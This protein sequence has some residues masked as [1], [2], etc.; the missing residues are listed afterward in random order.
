MMTLKRLIQGNGAILANASY[1]LGTGIATSGLGF[2]Y[3]WLAARFYPQAAVGIASAVISAMMLIGTIAMMGLGTLLIGELP[4]HPGQELSLIATAGVISGAVSIL[5]SL[6]FAGILLLGSNDLQILVHDPGYFLVFVVGVIL[7]T[8]TMVIDQAFIGLLHS[9]TQFVR[10]ALFAVAKLMLL[11]AGGVMIL[12]K[13]DGLIINTWVIGLILSMAI[14]VVF[15]LREYGSGGIRSIRLQPRTLFRLRDSAL[16][17]H[18][19]NLAL[20]APM[21]LMPV[22]VVVLISPEMNASFYVAWM[23]VSLIFVPV[24]SLTLVLY[25]VGAKNPELLASKLRFTLQLSVLAAA[26]CFLVLTFSADFL[27]HIFGASYAADGV[28]ALRI[29]GFGIFPLIVNDHYV[30]IERVQQRTSQAMIVIGLGFGLQLLL[31]IIGAKVAGLDGFCAGWVAAISLEAVY[32]APSVYRT[33][34]GRAARVV[35]EAVQSPE[36]IGEA[37]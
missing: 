5:F 6:V 14:P 10:N 28:T 34:R 3:W 12:S 8:M 29:L 2:A 35:L 24:G 13:T 36:V 18:L 21:R 1:L 22:L 23:I 33:L 25:A 32:M 26:F 9:R 16:T 7:T 11:G 27:M 15:L 17:H 4:R 31:S 30:A 37:L 20:D 19:L